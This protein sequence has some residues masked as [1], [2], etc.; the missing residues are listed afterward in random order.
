M[1][2]FLTLNQKPSLSVGNYKAIEQH[3]TARVAKWPV[4][5]C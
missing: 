4:F 1:K 5:Y 2:T 3:S